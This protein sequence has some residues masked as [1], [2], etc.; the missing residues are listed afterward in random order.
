MK[1]EFKA[2]L[3]IDDDVEMT[4]EELH[5]VLQDGMDTVC[6]TI[7]NVEILSQGD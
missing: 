1:I 5:D 2:T 6:V 4:P 3:W 7:S